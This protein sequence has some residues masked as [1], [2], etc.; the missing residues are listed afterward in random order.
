MSTIIIGLGNSVRADDGVG[1]AVARH[2]R[3]ELSGRTDCTVQELHAGGLRVVEAISGY[4]S[5]VLIDAMHTGRSEPGTVARLS[6]DDLG[7]AR[8]IDCIHDTSLPT[9]IA[10]WRRMNAPVPEE[11]SVWGIEAGDLDSFSEELTEPVAR[12]VP[13]AA[14]LILQELQRA[15]R[16]VT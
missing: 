13:V 15:Q 5:A 7:A 11:I 16:S 10:I 12:A 3:Q 1:L 4:D 2:L 6:L 9:A 8:N 14:A